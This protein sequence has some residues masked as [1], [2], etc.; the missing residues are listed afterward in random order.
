MKL[1]I[2]NS[3]DDVAQTACNIL[4]E[5]RLS[6]DSKN[7]VLGLATGSSAV[8]MYQ[9]LIKQNKDG[10]FDF[11][12]VYTFNLDEYVGLPAIHHQSFKY[13]M[14]IKLFDY[15]NL[16]K[17][18]IEFLNGMARDI[19]AECNRYEAKIE[20]FGGID[21][22]ILGIGSNGHIAFNEPE[23]PFDSRTHQIT[24]TQQTKNDNQRFFADDESVPDTALTMGIQSIMDSKSIILIATG[25]NKAE[26]VASMIN[27]EIDTRCP[28]SILQRHNDVHIICDGEAAGELAKPL[29]NKPTI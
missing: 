29:S 2:K 15:V 6:S 22:Q 10:N 24:L 19:P 12:D 13:F 26:A 5:K 27:G 11:S 20:D 17:E 1:I 21:V 3:H 4:M 9:E 18:N 23:T 16:P 28:A 8:K 14:H 25:K 7:F